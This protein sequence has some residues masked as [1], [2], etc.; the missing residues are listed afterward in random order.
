M[1]KSLIYTHGIILIIIKCVYCSDNQG[2][3]HGTTESDSEDEGD[4]FEV[5]QTTGQ[6][7][8]VQSVPIQPHPQAYPPPVTYTEYP[9]HSYQHPTPQYPYPTVLQPLEQIYQP[10]GPPV[11]IPPS[12][13]TYYGP[14]YQQYYPG[15]SPYPQVLSQPQSQQ[16]GS[17]QS[18]VPQFQAQPIPQFLPI[19]QVQYYVPQQYHPGIQYRPPLISQ[20]PI[21]ITH[22]YGPGQF[23]PQTTEPQPSETLAPETVQIEVGSED[24]I[25]GDGK[26]I[27]KEGE[28]DKGVRVKPIQTCKK[29]TFMKK[30]Q[31]GE[32]IKMSTNDFKKVI[33]DENKVRYTFFSNLEQLLCDGE[34][35]FEN[36]P[37]NKHCR[38]LIHHK[39]IS[40]FV[41]IS[42][43]GYYLVDP[44]NYG[45]R[46]KSEKVIKYLKLYTKD[47]VGNNLL[48]TKQ[49][50]EAKINDHPSTRVRFKSYARCTRVEFKG[51]V[52]WEKTENDGYPLLLIITGKLD[53]QLCFDG[54]NKI[55]R[56]RSG[57]YKKYIP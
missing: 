7:V 18:F 28:P 56:K 54:Y 13:P 14:P 38:L 41:L 4:N 42:E 35:I 40:R 5:T 16:Y 34:V 21:P 26:G 53:F 36:K 43:E 31:V 37:E 51:L 12:Q 9:Y 25:E 2:N 6:P 49:Y 8:D 20:H 19:Q 22:P 1:N 10:H 45:W 33:S 48:L 50:Y 30:N 11:Y 3:T 52:V 57:K 46:V 27:E 24:E 15:Y 23:Q 39:K 32:I 44:G 17:Y 55:Y 29:I 47:S